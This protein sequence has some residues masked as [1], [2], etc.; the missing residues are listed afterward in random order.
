MRIRER[1]EG[2]TITEREERLWRYFFNVEET[3]GR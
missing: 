1:G 3:I 2:E